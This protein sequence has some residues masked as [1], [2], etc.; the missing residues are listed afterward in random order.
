MC[1]GLLGQG[2]Y[3]FDYP[4]EKSMDEKV[5]KKKG[6]KFFGLYIIL[7]QDAHLDREMF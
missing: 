3:S 2:M 7:P 5:Y 1:G 4:R 6:K